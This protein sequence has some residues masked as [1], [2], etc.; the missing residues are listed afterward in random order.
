MKA[1]A[2]FLRAVI[3]SLDFPS[4]SL[5]ST[6]WNVVIF[7]VIDKRRESLYLLKK[8][9]L[10]MVKCLRFTLF[11]GE[12][13]K[14]N[15]RTRKSLM[16]Q[17]DPVRKLVVVVLSFFLVFLFAACDGGKAVMPAR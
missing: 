15:I 12:N 9:N 5:N 13:E 6:L 14:F 11:H 8:A 4:V 2:P 16:K 3:S 10:T 1:V 7:A 17:R